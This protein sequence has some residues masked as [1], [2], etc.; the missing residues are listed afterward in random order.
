MISKTYFTGILTIS[1]IVIGISPIKSQ[2]NYNLIIDKNLTSYAAAED[3]IT[4]HK[5]IYTVEGKFLK[6]KL[7]SEVKWYKKLSG[8][9]YRLG[10]SILVDLPIDHLLL[11]AQHEIYGH[12]ARYREFD[13]FNNHFNLNL[14]PP[15]DN[16]GGIAFKGEWEYDGIRITTNNENS[17]IYSAGMEGNTVLAQAMIPV[18]LGKQSINYR[19]SYFYFSNRHNITLYIWSTYYL[20][21][22]GC[23][24]T[25]GNDVKSYIYYVNANNYHSHNPYS[26]EDLS[27]QVF[28]NL[29]DP[30]QIYALYTFFKTYL[31]DGNEEQKIPMIPLGSLK[32]LP[33]FHLGLT[34]F[35][36]EFYFDN[37]F[38]ADKRIFT[39]YY[40]Q[41]DNRFSKFYGFGIKSYN[42]IINNYLSLNAEAGIWNQPS[43]VLGGK[44]ETETNSGF[45]G[46]FSV[47]LL[48]KIIKGD[49]PVSLYTQI[50]YKSSGYLEGER[51][52]E[53]LILKLGLSFT[54][55]NRK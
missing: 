33:S 3:L 40:R 12:G 10:K 20:E 50:G 14:P 17:A 45:G 13:Y 26:I 7:F 29:F 51:L 4:I 24:A 39:G 35:G 22:H 48:P 43:L 52:D 2:V 47:T 30:F 1:L 18:W 44:T 9:G 49:N 46:L 34:P 19:E 23:R 21:K 27:K 42:L 54:E 16:G 37:Y 36:T 25:D 38:V 5:A 28:I 55:L 8:I 41:G 15:Y 6:P 32:Y 11:L 31:W 53:G